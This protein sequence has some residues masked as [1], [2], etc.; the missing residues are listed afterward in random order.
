MQCDECTIH[1]LIIKFDAVFTFTITINF[2]CLSTGWIVQQDSKMTVVILYLA[3]VMQIPSC[4]L[5]TLAILCV[6]L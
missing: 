1:P 5:V 3:N 2:D 4:P 6:L